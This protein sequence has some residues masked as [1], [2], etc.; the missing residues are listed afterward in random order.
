MSTGLATFALSI[1]CAQAADQ[2]DLLSTSAQ[3]PSA[4]YV[5]AQERER[6]VGDANQLIRCDNQVLPC[7]DDPAVFKPKKSEL[8]ESTEPLS[9]AIKTAV[10]TKGPMIV[11]VDQGLHM[12]HVLQNQDGTLVDVFRAP[13]TTGKKSTPT[14]NGRM[15]VA[16]KRWDP[17]WK[18]PVSIDPKQKKVESYSKDTHNPLGVAWLGLDHGF[19]GLHGTNDPAKIGRYASHGCVRHKNEDIK[20][21]YGLVPVGTPVYIVATYTGTRLQSDDLEYLNGRIQ[22]TLVAHAQPIQGA[23]HI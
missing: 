7:L 13:N 20:K 2:V 10:P 3:A 18:P 12:T 6:V 5:M 9:D 14:P 16:D 15:K 11:V 4:P 19:I 21:L 8:L 1:Q 17:E 23:E 22:T